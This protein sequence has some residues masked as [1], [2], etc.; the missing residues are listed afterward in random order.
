MPYG[1]S[2]DLKTSVRMLSA[3]E[4][5]RVALPVSVYLIEHPRGLILVDTGWCRDLSPAGEYDPKAARQLLSP[6]L[7]SLYHPVLPAGMAAYEQ[8]AKLGIQPEDL[9]AVILTHLDP[10]HV[11]GLRHLSRAKRIILPEDEYFWSCRAVYKNRQPQKL[12][13]LYPME[14]PYY[15]GSPLGPIGWAID[16]F[17]DE[18]LQLV[19]LPGHTDGQAAILVQNGKSFVLLAADAA[20]SPRNWQEGV[21]PGFGFDRGRQ[22]KSLAW[23]AQTAADPRCAAVLCSHDPAQ[24]PGVIEF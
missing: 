13:M 15:R 12:W 14:R 21:T 9:E 17:G 1:N 19:N 6:A 3:P 7:A 11:A 24:A 20:Y 16:L 8:L 5:E 2:V 23:I 18:S 22:L 10:D 4:K